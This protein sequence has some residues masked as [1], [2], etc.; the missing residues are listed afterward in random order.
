MFRGAR[1][2][3]T[4]QVHARPALNPE[5]PNAL[6]FIG[7]GGRTTCFVAESERDYHQWA[8]ALARWWQQPP[9]STP[10]GG[11]GISSVAIGGPGAGSGIGAVGAGGMGAGLGG[12]GGYSVA[13]Y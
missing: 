6:E 2:L 8:V 9:G 10:A 5:R 1:W 3:H 12:G 4:L 7:D 13:G 11:G